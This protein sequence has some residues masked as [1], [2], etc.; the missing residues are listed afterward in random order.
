MKSGCYNMCKNFYY[1][2]GIVMVMW[3]GCMISLKIR[4]ISVKY[5]LYWCFFVFNVLV[6]S[7]LLG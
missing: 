1:V 5:N 3:R 4:L 7:V 6:V 2:E